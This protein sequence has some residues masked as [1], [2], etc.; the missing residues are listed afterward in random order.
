VV[1]PKFETLDL[2]CELVQQAGDRAAIV[3]L[4]AV[5][6]ALPPAA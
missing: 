5:A 4:D 1:D 6:A 3:D 2:I